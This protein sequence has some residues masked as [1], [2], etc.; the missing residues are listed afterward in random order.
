MPRIDE[1]DCYF[2]ATQSGAELDLLILMGERKIGYEFKYQDAPKITKSMRIALEDLQLER[3]YIVYPGDK[4][5]QLED[6][7]YLTNLSLLTKDDGD[8][9]SIYR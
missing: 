5:F 6:K 7:I 3:L 4:H 2:W 8:K 9:P 1:Q